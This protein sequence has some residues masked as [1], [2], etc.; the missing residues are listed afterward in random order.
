M[1]SAVPDAGGL[2]CGLPAGVVPKVDFANSDR[3]RAVG[4]AGMGVV[5]AGESIHVLDHATVDLE[6]PDCAAS[7]S[8]GKVVAAALN[9]DQGGNQWGEVNG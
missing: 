9:G 6:R 8:D 1:R 5:G 4:H 7:V 3:V 2:L